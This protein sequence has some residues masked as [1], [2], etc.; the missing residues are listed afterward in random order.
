MTDH[1]TVRPT[2]ASCRHPQPLRPQGSRGG[3]HNQDARHKVSSR[4]V[5]SLGC[6]VI[7]VVASAVL[8]HCTAAPRTASALYPNQNR[9]SVDRGRTHC[10]HYPSTVSRRAAVPAPESI[11][12]KKGQRRLLASRWCVIHE[13]NNLRDMVCTCYCCWKRRRAVAT[14]RRKSMLVCFWLVCS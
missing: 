11:A 8:Q 5:S 12:S 2:E 10:I 4:L 1:G 3:E 6:V 14:V 9:H 13:Y 7:V